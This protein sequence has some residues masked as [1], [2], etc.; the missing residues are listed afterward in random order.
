D[1]GGAGIVPAGNVLLKSGA[2]DTDL[3]GGLVLVAVRKAASD[4][5]AGESGHAHKAGKGLDGPRRD[6]RLASARAC[7]RATFDLGTNSSPRPGNSSSRPKQS[8][9]MHL[10]HAKTR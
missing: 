4:C 1:A 5:Q 10:A 8:L 7:R 3:K 6:L 2:K 9:R